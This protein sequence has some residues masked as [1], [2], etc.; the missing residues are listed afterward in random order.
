MA[1]NNNEELVAKASKVQGEMLCYVM[2][3][4]G[5]VKDL[6]NEQWFTLT[7]LKKSINN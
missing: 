2:Q 6:N 5:V 3:Q 1:K 7:D 4:L